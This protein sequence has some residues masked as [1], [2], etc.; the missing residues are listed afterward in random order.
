MAHVDNC[1]NRLYCYTAGITLGNAFGSGSSGREATVTNCLV[2]SRKFDI[3]NDN[4]NLE[5]NIKAIG[6]D[7]KANYTTNYV[8]PQTTINETTPSYDNA[9]NGTEWT[10][11]TEGDAPLSTWI[12]TSNWEANPN[13]RYMPVLKKTD[14]SAFSTTQPSIFKNLIS[15]S[16]AA[17]L[18]A[19]NNDVNS[20]A[21]DYILANDIDL[22]GYNGGNWTSIG[23]ESAPFIGTFNGDG[24]RITGL[25]IAEGGSTQNAGG[26]FGKV[27]NGSYFGPEIIIKNLGVE[28]AESG[29]HISNDIEFGGGIASRCDNSKIQNCYVTGGSIYGKGAVSAATHVN[30]G[31]IVGFINQAATIEHC[32]STVNI[33]VA[34]NDPRY[35]MVGQ[36]LL[37]GGILAETNGGTI[38]NCFATG[39]LS[40][41]LNNVTDQWFATSIGGISGKT[42]NISNCLAANSGGFVITTDYS[43]G[44][45]YGTIN[46][47]VGDGNWHTYTNNYFL[48]DIPKS[49]GVNTDGSTGS[50]SVNGADW[51]G[52]VYPAGIFD[53]DN[54][55]VSANTPESIFP[56]LCY[57]G[58]NILMP[59]QPDV[60]RPYKVDATTAPANGTFTVDCKAYAKVGE[61][62]TIT[63]SPDGG[64]ALNGL[65]E[66]TGNSG[67]VPVSG[68]ANSYT[69]TMPAE[70]VE[71]SA[72]FI[73]VYTVTIDDP[74]A[75]GSIEVKKADGTTLSSG[76]NIGIVNGTVLTITA[77]PATG[78]QLKQLTADGTP[79][80]GTTHT[81]TGNV[82]L[83]AEF[84]AKSG[85]GNEG[86]G[87][88][89]TTPTVYHTVTLPAVEGATTDPVAGDYEV[90]A[91]SSFRFYLTLN[92]E[93]DKSE[94]V[95]TTDRSETI[96]PRSSDGAYIIK[97]IREPIEILIDGIIKNPDPVGNETVTANQ[98]KVWAAEGYLHIEAA[99]DGQAYIFT[100]DG[101]LQ[102]LQP[103]TA[104]EAI[105]LPLP[106][107]VYIV[108]IGD[109]RFKVLL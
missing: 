80:T 23:T 7:G 16:T 18:A 103:V 88:G 9:A 15:I 55:Q 27:G 70:A 57:A 99:T 81:V 14:G 19:I 56:K 77:T 100:A 50:S 90:E 61:V 87:G 6:I 101:R 97:Y 96:T 73:E 20:L 42:C 49:V 12:G 82:T 5:S 36:F 106:K 46:N 37:I 21:A 41:V 45:N 33:E 24:H 107:G 104:G 51:D 17:E 95:V 53:N 83:S 2:L 92:K 28:I 25:A 66:V 93:Y 94:P 72:S 59:N 26:L 69:F 48:I 34:C 84:E 60:M 91:W 78:Y 13:T 68:S 85:G 108:R 44:G 58:T 102:K 52:I 29:I 32:Y 22:S 54:W 3:S 67:P 10:A 89:T 74:I 40:A 43:G 109:E 86:D 4:G 8:S 31:G 11:R 98:S 30:I 38:T 1:S 71:V 76:A 39:T 75:N 79:I 35:E 105:T 63:T 65:P 64:Y 62:I 47:I